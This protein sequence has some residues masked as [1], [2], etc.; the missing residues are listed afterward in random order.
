MYAIQ[1]LGLSL[2]IALMLS[3]CAARRY[4]PVPIV[5]T[6]TAST[7]EA[8]SLGDP[9]LHEFVEKNVGHAVTPWPPNAWDSAALSL[10]ALYFSPALDAAPTNSMLRSL[11]H[12]GG[13]SGIHSSGAVPARK[14]FE[15][16]GRPQG[17]ALPALT[18]VSR[19]PIP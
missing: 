17:G 8:R 9:G 1:K 13:R 12:S 15:R 11:Y 19:P 3:G 6:Q 18:F 10:V 2:S 7:L 14:S 5:P 16:L 4:Q